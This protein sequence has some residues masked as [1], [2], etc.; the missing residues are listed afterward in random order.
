MADISSGTPKAIALELLERIATVE[1]RFS[2]P[3]RKT[4]K[5]HS[6]S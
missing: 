1:R 2:V 6:G 3:A 4:V 5:L